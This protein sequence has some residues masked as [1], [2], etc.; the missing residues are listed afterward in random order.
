MVARTVT[1]VVADL[2][3]LIR[4][5]EARAAA[6]VC[7]FCLRDDGG[8]TSREHIF[9]EGVGNHKYVLQPGIVCDRCNNGPLAETC[10]AVES[11]LDMAVSDGLMC[12]APRSRRYWPRAMAIP[13][14]E[15]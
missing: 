1:S 7:L 13:G 2:D 9:S 8:F 14:S 6:G 5:Q 3:S 10:V 11:A 15:P 12:R 4:I